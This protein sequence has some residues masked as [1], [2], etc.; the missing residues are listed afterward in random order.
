MNTTMIAQ[1]MTTDEFVVQVHDAYDETPA[2][3]ADF[4]TPDMLGEMDAVDGYPFCPEMYY[5]DR[6]K[7]ALYAAGWASVKGPSYLT[8][9]FLVGSTLPS[10]EDDY[11]FIRQGGA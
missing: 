8:D 4:L 11:E 10:I 5:A 7:Q 6:A 1:P 9:D 2:D 3:N